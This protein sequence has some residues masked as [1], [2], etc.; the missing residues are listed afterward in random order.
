MSIQ[1]RYDLKMENGKMI[2]VTSRLVC[3]ISVPHKTSQ[4]HSNSTVYKRAIV[5]KVSYLFMCLH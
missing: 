2:W 1:R 5:N 4:F 3:S